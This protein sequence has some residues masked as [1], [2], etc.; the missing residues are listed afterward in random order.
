MCLA[1]VC[2]RAVLWVG[3]TPIARSN[4][5]RFASTYSELYKSGTDY[6]TVGNSYAVYTVRSDYG[7]PGRGSG[8]CVLKSH[9][10]RVSV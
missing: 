4:R 3:S 5:K 10:H 6:S 2:A 1:C 8:D 7:D 9:S